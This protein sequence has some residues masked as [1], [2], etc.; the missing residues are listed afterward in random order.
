MASFKSMITKFTNNM[1]VF[2]K[3]R[4]IIFSMYNAMKTHNNSNDMGLYTGSILFSPSEGVKTRLLMF[5]T[6]EEN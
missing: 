3:L 4:Q 6:L 2:F 1:Q 5:F